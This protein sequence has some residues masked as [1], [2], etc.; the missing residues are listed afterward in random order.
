MDD[1]EVVCV[2]F[3]VTVGDIKKAIA[4]GARTFEEIQNET[5][6]GTGC[7][8]CLGAAQELVSALLA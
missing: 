1:N 3:Q 2:C 6:L 5:Q 4:N 8:G 7:G